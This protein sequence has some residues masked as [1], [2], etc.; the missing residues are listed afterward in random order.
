MGKTVKAIINNQTIEI[1]VLIGS[2]GEKA[3]DISKLRQQTG[4]ITLDPGYGNTG[5]C[6]SKITYVNGEKGVLRYRGIPIDELAENS[7]FVETAYLLIYGSLPD[8]KQKKDF[9]Y[10]LTEH[11]LLHEDI[12]IFFQNFPR[13]SNP[14]GILSSM[15]N[16]MRFFY[17]TLPA[18]PN[19]IT[20][21][22]IARLI[23]KMRTMAAF[24]Y[25]I[26]RGHK[27]VYPNP[28]YSY[29]ENFL[30][31]M[32]DNPVKP[33][34]LDPDIVKALSI[35]WIVR[36]DLEQNN[37]T[38]A[39]RLVG[40]GR[41]NIHAAI[42]A[43]TC[44]L[45]GPLHGGATYA[46]Y[47][48]LEEIKKNKY[49][50]NYYINKAKDPNDSFRLFGFGHRIYRTYDPRSL[51]LKNTYKSLI[52]DKLKDNSLYEIALELEDAALNDDFFKEHKIFPNIDLY[53]GVLLKALGIPENMFTVLFAIGR[54]PGWIAQWKEEADDPKWKLY[55][56]RQIYIGSEKRDYVPMDK[57]E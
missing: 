45:W 7:T 24:S 28:K 44:A 15:V 3:L 25:K 23:S 46:V 26:S 43:G 5:S 21:D 10:L 27:V 51:I 38:T 53:S 48:M 17:N 37:S 29:C 56:P 19:T 31:M 11:S 50:I 12:N 14:M 36:A 1:P 42:S 55:R 54:L 40:S 4:Y 49:D 47:N 34:T 41:V 2:Q 33:Y 35:F 57:R 39:V 16:A 13:L 32:F 22:E 8:A 6:R 30:N 20:D 9:S 52:Q 18:S